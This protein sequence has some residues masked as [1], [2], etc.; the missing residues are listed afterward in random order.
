MHGHINP[1]GLDFAGNDKVKFEPNHFS[2]FL[3]LLQMINMVEA[4]F[5]ICLLYRINLN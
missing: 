3:F 2:G 4:A 5:N 1:H